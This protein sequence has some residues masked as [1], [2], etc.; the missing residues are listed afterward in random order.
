MVFKW[1]L[2]HWKGKAGKCKIFPFGPSQWGKRICACFEHWNIFLFI[3]KIS[4]GLYFR[5]NSEII[6]KIN[7]YAIQRP[8]LPFP[9]S[10]QEKERERQLG[11]NSYSLIK[12]YIKDKF[13]NIF[14]SKNTN[15][16]SSKKREKAIRLGKALSPIPALFFNKKN[17]EIA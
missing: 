5:Y 12:K 7:N 8:P 6:T 9:T 16:P 2:P 10:C 14:E 13:K 15:H 4:E 3:K 1:H 17:D 11:W